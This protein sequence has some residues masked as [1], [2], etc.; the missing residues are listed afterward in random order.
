MVQTLDPPTVVT[1]LPV[2]ADPRFTSAI[3][4]TD[5][6]FGSKKYLP[7]NSPGTDDLYKVYATVLKKHA[8]RF[9]YL[10]A[11][12]VDIFWKKKGLKKDGSGICGK[13]GPISGKQAAYTDGHFRIDIAADACR[14]YELS[15]HQ[16]EALL[17][18]E[19]CHTGV[20]EAL[21]P[22][23]NRHELEM[24]F[25]EV[26][27]YGLWTISLQAAAPVFRQAPLGV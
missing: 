4:P 6:A 17:F 26:T 3:V 15:R 25:D 7:G 20:T 8:A 27:E 5:E 24:F 12:D 1:D 16:L 23:M 21:K 10:E 18:H 19:M 14:V 2:T 9:S 13:C 22:K 11:F